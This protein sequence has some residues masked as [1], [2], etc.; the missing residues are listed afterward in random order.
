[1][2]KYIIAGKTIKE[3]SEITGLGV[4]LIRKRL[5][6][7]Y[8]IDRIF[9]AKKKNQVPRGSI[10]DFVESCAKAQGLTKKA[11]YMRFYRGWSVEEIER[12]VKNGK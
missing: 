5:G 3:W 11:I 10:L 7:H 4:K 12:G 2:G 1:M 9:E 6:E 8:D